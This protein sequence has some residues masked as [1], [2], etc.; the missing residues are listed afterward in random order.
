ML[1]SNSQ[2]AI[3]P[4]KGYQTL[5]SCHTLVWK[6]ENGAFI[7]IFMLI[8]DWKNYKIVFYFLVATYK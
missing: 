7:F 4:F 8:K 6:E 5:I 2:P 1:A 3:S